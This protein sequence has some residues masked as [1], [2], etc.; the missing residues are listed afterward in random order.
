MLAFWNCRTDRSSSSHSS[1]CTARS[2]SIRLAPTVKFSP[3][4]PTTRASK[5]ARASF[6]AAA[7]W[8]WRRRRARSSWSGTR[9]GRTPSPRSTRLAPGVLLLHARPRALTAATSMTPGALGHRHGARRAE[10][11]LRA[12][13]D[14]VEASC[15]PRPAASRSAAGSAGPRPAPA[16][17]RAATPDGVHEAERAHAPA[18]APLHGA[19]DGHHVVGDLGHAAT[20]R[21]SDVAESTRHRNCPPCP[22]R[23]GSG[24]GARRC[25]PW[26]AAAS[27]DGKLR[28]APLAVLQGLPVQGADLLRPPSCR[29]PPPVFSPSHSLDHRPS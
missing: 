26:S 13:L 29:S 5:C 28:L 16:P 10:H 25:R 22:C 6:T 11:G 24:R 14:L 19:V 1:S 20:P 4:L 9:P 27:T 2:T 17:P 3:W 15:G 7:A 18:V 23:P 21:R 8:R 12:V